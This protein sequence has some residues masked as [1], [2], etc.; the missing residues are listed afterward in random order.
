MRRL[1]PC[2]SA[3]R[4]VVSLRSMLTGVGRAGGVS[5][6]IGS[7]YPADSPRLSIGAARETLLVGANLVFA[8]LFAALSDHKDRPYR[9]TIQGH[10]QLKTAVGSAFLGETVVTL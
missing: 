4:M 1:K 8:R 3:L 10:I 5:L 6:P 7:D 9:R 2:T